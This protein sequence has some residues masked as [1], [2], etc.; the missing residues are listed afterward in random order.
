MKKISNYIITILILLFAIGLIA[1]SSSNVIII[2]NS[3]ELFINTVFPSLF[4]FLIV[5]ELLS[6][7][8]LIPFITSKFGIVMDR[9]FN[10]PKIASYP[11]IIG[12]FSG[13]PVGAKIVTNLRLENKISKYD[14]NRL[15]IFTNNP[16]PMFVIGSVGIGFF[17]NKSIG[18]LLLLV[19]FISCIITTFCIGHFFNAKKEMNQLIIQKNYQL[20]H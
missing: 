2:N 12:L 19:Q 5:V 6:Y 18:F 4:P 1:F 8:F 13:Y 7:T 17:C 16:G 15:L 10:L 20:I 14:G 9:I 11:F 3:F